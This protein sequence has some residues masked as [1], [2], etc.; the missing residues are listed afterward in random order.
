MKSFI[1]S[2]LFRVGA[3]L[4]ALYA[5]Y[6][7]IS[8]WRKRNDGFSIERIEGS[9]PYTISW[10]EPNDSE[11]IHKVKEIINQPF[12]YL[13]HGFQF[14]AFVSK[15][16]KYVL[17]FLRKQRLGTHAFYDYFP[18]LPFV[19]ELK[20]KKATKR[21]KRASLLFDS[22]KIAYEVVPE[23][24]GLLFVHLNKTNRELQR[25]KLIDRLGK[26]YSIDLDGIE[27]L[28]QYKAELIKPT[29]KAL[30]EAGELKKAKDRLAQIFKLMVST[31]KKGVLDTDGALIHKNNVGF[32]EDRAIFIDVGRLV[33][34]ETIKTKSRFTYDLKRLKPL[35]RWLSTRYPP[36]AAYFNK[37]Q[38]KAI[39][40]FDIQDVA[41]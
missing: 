9:L 21:A 25:V 6:F 12:H 32:L 30:M 23:E 24:T 34:K 17:K 35:Y 7:G 4:I 22:I 29:I 40:A 36:L 28:L 8:G 20:A 15:D 19:K 39:A 5:V 3:I 31:A 11:K 18:D 33:M 16:G 41:P 27:F 13:S 14:Y 10:K 38:A 37:E 2:R 1:S 26:E